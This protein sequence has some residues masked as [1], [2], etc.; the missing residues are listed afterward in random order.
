MI[1]MPTATLLAV[2]FSLS[3]AQVH[4]GGL[5]GFQGSTLVGDD[6]VNKTSERYPLNVGKAGVLSTAQ[7]GLGLDFEWPNYAIRTGALYSAKGWTRQ[8]GDVTWDQRINYFVVPV[9][10]HLLAFAPAEPIRPYLSAG[11]YW[12]GLSNAE[13]RSA[14]FPQMERSN[15]KEWKP[16][17]VGVSVGAGAQG[18]INRY[19]IGAQLRIHRDLTVNFKDS[20]DT[21][22]QTFGLDLFAG[23]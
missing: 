7:L 23:I 17:A 6:A 18:R 20:R 5:F 14:D 19:R 15:T 3:G 2:L 9:E 1:A 22:N 13:I 4:L 10:F 16:S 11:L 8:I 21:Y 12:S